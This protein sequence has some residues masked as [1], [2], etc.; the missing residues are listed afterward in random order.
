MKFLIC[1]REP[2]VGCDYTIGCGQTWRIVEAESQADAVASEVARLDN[3]SVR[4][5]LEPGGDHELSHY[6]IHTVS[7][8]ADVLD[9]LRARMAE[10]KELTARLAE[11]DAERAERAELARLRRKYP[12][13]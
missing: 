12:D 7:E 8:S 2:R 5:M 11:M 4:W 6:I 10:A 3:E 1:K 9:V 13:E